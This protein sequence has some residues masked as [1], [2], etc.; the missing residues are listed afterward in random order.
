MVIY[1]LS[2]LSWREVELRKGHAGVTDVI[3]L[4]GFGVLIQN[5]VFKVDSKLIKH[6][7]LGQNGTS[8][9]YMV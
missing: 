9:L 7:C 1:S 6:W 2:A 5:T 4:G 8:K 3:E